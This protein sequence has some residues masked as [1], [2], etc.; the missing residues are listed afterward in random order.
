MQVTSLLWASGFSSTEL[1]VFAYTIE[2]IFDRF[3]RFAW[4]AGVTNL[5]D[6]ISLSSSSQ[7]SLQPHS[8][9]TP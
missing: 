7:S 4:H 8:D 6:D 1:A 5:K 9:K 2:V 3:G